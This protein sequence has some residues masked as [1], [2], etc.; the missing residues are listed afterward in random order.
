MT[1]DGQWQNTPVKRFKIRDIVKSPTKQDPILQK[2]TKD[3]FSLFNKI[4]QSKSELPDKV[5][6]KTL[7]HISSKIKVICLLKTSLE[8]SSKGEI[9]AMHKS[10]N[11]TFQLVKQNLETQKCL[12]YKYQHQFFSAYVLLFEKSN[13][14]FSGG[15]DKMLVAYN[16]KNGNVLKIL[17]L[18]IGD[19]QCLFK[20]GAIV[21]VG[22]TASL[23]FLNSKNL[24]EIPTK[25]ITTQCRF[26]QCI[27]LR[28]KFGHS[29]VLYLAG[30]G[31]NN[32]NIT[33]CSLP[34]QVLNL[35]NTESLPKN[36]VTFYMHSS[37]DSF[38]K[39]VKAFGIT[40]RFYSSFK[41]ILVQIVKLFI[42]F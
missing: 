5:E 13:L 32:P 28:I 21:C 40:L 19:V 22:G 1:Q 33:T 16:L 29:P 4:P 3:S 15:G 35:L 6:L 14:V 8:I 11:N 39:F 36:K 38:H 34:E 41:F 24:R 20:A 10:D 26:I 17:N 42:K 2:K 31:N 23:K 30:Y 7:P 18:G 37:K 9:L 12:F 27:N 25:R